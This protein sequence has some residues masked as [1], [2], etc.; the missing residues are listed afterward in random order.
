MEVIPCVPPRWRPESGGRDDRFLYRSEYN[1]PTGTI[2]VKHP[3]SIAM[4]RGRPLSFDPDEAL[5]RA[6]AVFWREGFQGAALSTL[7]EAMGIN[8]PS[9]YAAFGDKASLYLKALRR[10]AQQE[11]AKHVEA[12][13]R[14]ADGRDA[15]ESFLRSAVR[16][17]TDPKKP[18]GCFVVNGSADCDL[19]DT[20]PEVQAALR[21]ALRGGEL[22]L[23]QRLQRAQAEGQLSADVDTAA[24]AAYFGTVMS[25][26]GVQ[27]KAGATRAKLETVVRA[28]MQAWPERSRTHRRG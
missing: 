9:L 2:F 8:K 24:L 20:P 10:Y 12:L 7:T 28:A 25:G 18:A 27:A 14:E 13:E 26:L 22:A 5:D 11:S 1:I 17:L 19:A 16:S 3:P 4:S 6:L 21:E 23:R 15:V